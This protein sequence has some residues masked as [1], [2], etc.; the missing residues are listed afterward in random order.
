MCGRY[1]YVKKYPTLCSWSTYVED[2]YRS[3]GDWSVKNRLICRPQNCGIF[4]SVLDG[5]GVL[6][7]M[8]LP[9]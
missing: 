2:A 6:L 3:P 1:Y 5:T 8:Q 7:L 9:D 4:T